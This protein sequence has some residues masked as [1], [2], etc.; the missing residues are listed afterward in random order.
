MHPPRFPR[1]HRQ[2]ANSASG[3][4]KLCGMY[5]LARI[6][7]DY[8]VPVAIGGSIGNSIGGSGKRSSGSA[9][10][11]VVLHRL[12]RFAHMHGRIVL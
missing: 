5:R 6:G 3:P 12:R 8:F 7:Q 1:M 11:Q 10:A 2:L 4:A 9:Q